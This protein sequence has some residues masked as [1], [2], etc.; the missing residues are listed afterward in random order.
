MNGTKRHLLV[1]YYFIF[2][3]QTH[4][5]I[6]KVPFNETK[7]RFSSQREYAGT[8]ADFKR[9]K[10]RSDHLRIHDRIG[11]HRASEQVNNFKVYRGSLASG[12]T[13]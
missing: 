9:L 3:L 4:H 8:T 5:I 2:F 10:E 11:V 7:Q 13:G 12:A 6:Y 1:G